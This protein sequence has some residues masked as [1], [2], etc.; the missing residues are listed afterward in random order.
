MAAWSVE[1]TLDRWRA[2]DL[3]QLC[4]PWWVRKMP[5]AGW[6]ALVLIFPDQFECVSFAM[7][8]TGPKST[9]SAKDDAGAVKSAADERAERLAAA[10]RANL[11]R[12]K[13]AD[14]ARRSTA[15]TGS[16]PA[17]VLRAGESDADKA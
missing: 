9:V 2:P 13:A 3:R 6:A 4:G 12:R 5:L 1:N 15:A 11:K 17:E 14:R 10:L 8:E 16:E 7:P